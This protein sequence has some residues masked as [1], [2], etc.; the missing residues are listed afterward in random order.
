MPMFLATQTAGD[1]VQNPCCFINARVHTPSKLQVSIEMKISSNK[2]LDSDTQAARHSNTGLPS[3]PATN[4]DDR[5][6]HHRQLHTSPTGLRF[7]KR[8][9][10]PI[11][12]DQ[13]S[14]TLT[15][16]SVLAAREIRE[17]IFKHRRVR[18]ERTRN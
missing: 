1:D 17:Q 18:R 3:S 9:K 10:C 12:S 11:S 13:S 14:S 16:H 6:R 8:P 5:Q 4:V 2:V 15:R 7:V